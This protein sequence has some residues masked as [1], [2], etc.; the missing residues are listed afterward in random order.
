MAMRVT[1]RTVQVLGKPIEITASQESRGA[2]IAS[3][4]YMGES[5]Q[6]TGRS[7]NSVAKQWREMAEYKG[8]G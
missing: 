3:G 5:F 7:E 2:W 8:N 1:S 6:V 4:E